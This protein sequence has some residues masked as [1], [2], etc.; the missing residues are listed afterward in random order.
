M[1]NRRRFLST[2]GAAAGAAAL[3]DLATA[4]RLVADEL[5]QIPRGLPLDRFTGLRERYLLDPAILYVNHAS[6]GTI[7]RMVHEARVR[8]LAL[9]ETNPWAYMW[10]DDWEEPRER[11]RATAGL[12]LGCLPEDV[13]FTHNTTEGFNVLAQGLPLGSGDEVLFSSLNHPGASICWHY[14]GSTRGYSVRQFD[15]PVLDIPRFTADDVLDVYDRHITSRT[16]VLVF[17][18]IDNIVGLRYP[19]REL[20]ALAHAKGVEFVAADGAQALGMI[21]LAVEDSGVDF[22]A[23]SPHKWLQAP[24]GLGLLYVRRAVRDTLR[25][26]WVTWGQVRW[27]GTV[28]VLEDYGTRNLPE[29]IALGDAMG[30]QERLGTQNKEMR[31]RELWEAARRIVERTPALVW[32]SPT[33]WPLAASLYAVEVEGRRS[34]DVFQVLNRDMGAVFRAFRTQGL[35]T[36][37]ISPNVFNSETELERLFNAMAAQAD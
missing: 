3:A 30:F 21:P 27:A 13:A 15:F 36:S 6:I 18:H 37:R 5:R 10:G 29:V 35:N 25:S 11:V 31:Y 1:S 17:P 12:M 2:F 32:R 22:Y 34:E 24:K 20:A 8:Y 23:A 19:A 7:P 28:R 16:R 33:T 9:C 14:H 4:R 26:M